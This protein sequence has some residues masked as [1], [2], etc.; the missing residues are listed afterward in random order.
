MNETGKRTI[1]TVPQ[2]SEEAL[3]KAGA[4]QSA[5][6]NSAG[7]SSIA[8][9]TKGVIQ[10]FNVG[11]ERMLG[12]AAAEV[13]NR[14]TPADISDPQELIAR[15]RALSAELETT[16]AP[17]FEALVFK[18][19]HGIEDIYELTYIRKDGSRFPVM[20]SVTALRDGRDAIIGYLLIGTDNT[21]G[22]Q[23]EAERRQLVEMQEETNKQLQ[24]ANL[25]LRESEEK[26]A[27]TL[28][29]IGDA[30]IATD[31]QARVTL[32]NPLAEKLTGWSLADATG[33]PVDE[34]FH[35][36]NKETRLPAAIPIMETLAHGTI[37][38]LANHAVLIARDGSECDIADSC[39]PIR[40]RDG[41]VIGAVLVFRD[42]T[43]E[44]AAQ[45]ALR[46]S[47]ALVQTI[48]N[49]VVDGI[50][51]LHA[52]GGIIQT[53]N[54]AVEQMFGYAAAELNGQTF[55]LLIPELDR[56]QRIGSLEYYRASDEDRAVGLGREVV[57]RRRDG[58]TFP[59]EIAVSEMLLGGQ[60]YFTG[61]LRDIT[62]RRQAEEALL[63][64]GALQ[65]AIFN[66]A[67]FSSIATDAKGVIQIFNL[68]AE[69][70]LGYAAGEVLDRITPADISDPQELIVRADALSAE[71]GTPITPGF[72]ALVFK[73]SRGIEDIYE[74]T[75]I[76]KDGSRFPAV[77]SVTALR[78]EHGAIIGYL[79]IGTDN[80]ARKEIEAEQKQLGQRLRDQQFYTRSLFESNIDALM[81]TDPAGIITDVNKQMEALTD[82]TRDELIGAPFRKYFTNPDQAAAVIKLVLSEKKVTDYELTVRIRDGKETVVSLN[83]TTFYDRDRVLQGVFAA[84]RDVT[85][86]KI[87]DQVLQER[88]VE[89]ENA[90]SA[91]ENANLAKSDFLSNM[92]HEIR[93][94]MNAIVGMSHLALKTELT[95]RQ[96]DYIRKI[97]ISSRHLLGII[98]DILDFSKIEE[99]R[100]TIEHTEF[101]LEKVLGNVA[102][103]I[104]EKASAKGLEMIFDVD[105][106]VP[107]NLIG[108]PLRLGQILIN[109]TNNAI[110]YTEHGEIDIAI[111]LREQ[112][113]E[114]V[115]L[116][117]TVRDTGSGL[118]EEQMGRLFQ[119][120]SQ[121]DA[122]TTREFGGTGLGLAISKRLAELMG[123]EV[124][125]ES[126]AGKG[127]TFWFTAR[128]GR[129]VGEHH[130]PALSA[131]LRGKRVLVV[132]DNENAGQML[133]DL[134]DSMG[135]SV[136][137]A[138]SGKAAIAA[139]VRAERKG[140]PY[141][142]VFLDWQMPGMDGNETAR[143]I[144]KLPIARPQ[145]IMV[146]AFG[147]EEVL[148]VAEDAG[149]EDVL[150]KPVNPSVL[151]DSVIRILGGAVDGVRTSGETS[152]DSFA[153]F[154]AI[155]GS[156]I[157]L[158]EDN[159][160][161]QEVATELLCDAGFVVDLAR[162]GEIAL[163]M[164]RT[165]D[166]GMVLMD[167]QMPVMDGLTATREIRGDVRFRDLPVVAMTANASR[168]DRDR[169]LA[170]GMNDHVSKP[171]EPE[172]LWKALL[173]WITPRQSAA[174][175]PDVRPQELDD[176]DLPSGIEGLDTVNGLRRVLGRKPLYI[177]MLRKFV[178][179]Q[180]SAAAEIASALEGDLP[181]AAE[182]LA[183][184]LK[185]VSGSIGATGLQGLAEK[186][187]TAIRD[188]R[189]RE[190]I[191]ACFDE[192]KMPL[193]YLLSQLAEKIPEERCMS[194]ATASPAQ[195][196]VV[197]DRLAAMLA[198]DDAEAVDVLEAN[199]NLLNAAFPRHYRLIDEG[200]QSFDFETA[201]AALRA[202]TGTSA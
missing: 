109:Y 23:V 191:D 145:M 188:S 199:A 67:N 74:L 201:L 55:G 64:A 88:T 116:Y 29:S 138:E 202:A 157:L 126:E 93:T 89:L 115:L 9:D 72:E 81:T 18:A 60:L 34:I 121:A 153:Q 8:T 200:I 70:M 161:N 128:L 168:K 179:G 176:V 61:I 140:A 197:C 36:V 96:R 2:Q 112:T 183:H 178:A 95:P 76:R 25:T 7:F 119:R 68:G 172:M 185:S 59:L 91:A 47:T 105:R 120:F 135:L 52:Q 132:D 84:A 87:L 42:V 190:E 24:Q 78:D 73:A 122:S 158:V 173:Q 63:Q 83:A 99:G 53:V 169:C 12:Y 14:I 124:G 148:K 40:D 22:K 187:E 151:Y 192:L 57:G 184:T 152:F 174:A 79:L 11:A 102:S 39:A 41:Q 150:I 193:A 100:L 48:F 35:I 130:H 98:N 85:E 49:T 62:A 92:S 106:E 155:K 171:I 175:T 103:L 170:A 101:E 167:M 156:R 180:Q 123:G 149:I 75:Y 186:L 163:E 20:E 136:D 181:T 45:Q 43:G 94:P 114:D 160:L 33:R 125:V 162:N 51:T 4:L 147:R 194:V 71:L 17:G 198:D 30:V 104:A 137:Q 58:S 127:S 196:G 86:R 31:A 44:Y 146:T 66:S 164:I 56:D 6:F 133:A 3:L 131:D 189:P 27:V 37:Q 50:I 21:R 118:T 141:A 69:R 129:G 1:D 15:A 177:S 117:C 80:T 195:L 139:V 113:D 5:I 46:D 182:Q 110:T 26:L 38:G 143:Q 108:D 19:S 77:V 54:P 65:S 82:C 166:Y 165:G 16:I 13:L 97:K 107:A 142:I 159:D 28:N 32:L 111:S 134:L 154:A 10:I 144:G 90:K